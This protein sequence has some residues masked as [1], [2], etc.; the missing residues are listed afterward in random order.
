MKKIAAFFDVDGT[1]FRNS[2]LIEHFKMLIKFEFI[3][4]ASF[5]GDI[6]YKF[7]MWEERKGSYDDYL[8]E[9]V[10]IYVDCIKNIDEKDINYVAQRVIENRAEKIYTYS[11]NKIKEHLDNGH[12]VIIISGSPSFLVDKMATKLN[13][14]DFIATEYL[15]DENNRYSGKNIPMWDSKSKIKAINDF[16]EKYDIDLSKSYAYGDTTGDYGMFEMVGNPIAIN[17]AKRLFEKILNNKDIREKIKIIV[18]RKDMVY[19]FN[20]DVD[21]L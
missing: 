8:E 5:V 7:K 11:R 2:L 18:E 20:P 1:I 21:Y 16:A 3:D 13:A 17:P 12:L 9:L 14:T 4:E 10:D 15:L 6:K 19:I